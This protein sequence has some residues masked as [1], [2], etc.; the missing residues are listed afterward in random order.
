VIHYDWHLIFILQPL[1]SSSDCNDLKMAMLVYTVEIDEK[2]GYSEGKPPLLGSP[3]SCLSWLL[4]AIL[5]RTVIESRWT[6]KL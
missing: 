4:M 6:V 3:Q 2:H 1:F 5:L